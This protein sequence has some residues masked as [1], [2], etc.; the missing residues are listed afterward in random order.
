MFNF[1]MSCQKLGIKNTLKIK[2]YH[3][4]ILYAEINDML[5]SLFVSFASMSHSLRTQNS[6]AHMLT[7][8]HQF[9]TLA[10]RLNEEP[11]L[12]YHA[13]KHNY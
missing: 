9:S 10:T 4:A 3:D 8:H 12:Q 11:F 6:H 5:H 7:T 1:L 13:H 2:A